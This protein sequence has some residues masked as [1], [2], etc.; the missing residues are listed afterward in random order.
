M[1]NNKYKVT[2]LH[3]QATEQT[4]A[5][6]AKLFKI[7]EKK[8]QLI[9]QKDAFVI[10]KET[11]KA[12]AEKF[13]KAIMATGVNCVITQVANEED[14]ALPSIE[15]VNVSSKGKPLTD[16]TRPDITPLHT[17]HAKLSLVDRPA[18]TAPEEK[19]PE[20]ITNV[21]PAHFCP[22][23]GTIRA[24]VD[25]ACLQC[26][27][28]P[29][30][31]NR[32]NMK[33]KIIKA[34]IALIILAG[35]AAIGLPFYQQYAKQMQIEDD[36][37]LAFDTRN[38]VTEFIERTN[39]WPNQNIDA[40]LDKDISNRSIKSVTVT[41]NALITVVIRGNVLKGEEQTLIFTPNILK[42]LIVWNCL[43]GTLADEFRPDICRPHPVPHSADE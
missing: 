16:I 39:F 7:S 29:E 40:G 4:L 2:V 37:K 25:S 5:K 30:E 31:Q 17:E 9:L 12:T 42:G 15:E 20:T 26:G 21:D 10:K 6:F 14:S 22:E 18:E 23:C 43:K 1:G 11:D 38:L 24:S 36:L 41:E 32:S 33:S 8:A 13:H 28:D 27:Y 19:D 34:V 35:V 3:T